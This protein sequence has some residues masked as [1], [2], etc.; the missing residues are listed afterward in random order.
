VK[1]GILLASLASTALAVWIG[2][3]PTEER[4][5]R[6]SGDDALSVAFGDAKA[7]IGRVFVEKADSYFHGGVDM[8]GSHDCVRQAP[9]DEQSRDHHSQSSPKATASLDPWTW[10]N[11]HVRAPQV[12]RHLEGTRAIE[13]IPWLWAAVKA[14]PHDTDA[15]T[16]VWYVAA[17]QMKDADLALKIALE[18]VRTN[19]NALDAACVLGR[20]YRA[21]KTRDPIRSTAA[22]EKAR[23]LGKAKTRLTPQEQDSFLEALDYLAATERTVGRLEALLVDARSV[24]PQHIITQTIERRL[25][26]ALK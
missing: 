3:L 9:G 26:D 20:S 16:T 24:N 14:N 4:P 8:D 19:P 22:F 25:Q 10:I 13:L 6:T 11:S 1:G 5:Q 15:W 18:A 2:R 21:E 23:A 7:T 17:R 12:E